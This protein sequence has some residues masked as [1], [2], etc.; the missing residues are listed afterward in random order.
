MHIKDEQM[1][2][3][4]HAKKILRFNTLN[5]ESINKSLILPHENIPIYQSPGSVMQI[6]I[7]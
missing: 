4:Y 3:K 6:K 5:D 2:I 7:W 1:S